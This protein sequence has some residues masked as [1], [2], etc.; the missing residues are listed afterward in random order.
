MSLSV[1]E[2]LL[3]SVIFLFSNCAKN[4][5]AAKEPVEEATEE[6]NAEGNNLDALNN[7]ALDNNALDNNALDNNALDADDELAETSV[8]NAEPA[9]DAANLDNLVSTD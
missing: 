3:L 8:N 7:N 5:E 2:T 9:Q 4:S 6:A 1:K